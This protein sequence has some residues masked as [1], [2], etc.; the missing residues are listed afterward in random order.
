MSNQPADIEYAESLLVR[1]LESV[2]ETFDLFAGGTG[3]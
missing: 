1:V 2:R 3:E